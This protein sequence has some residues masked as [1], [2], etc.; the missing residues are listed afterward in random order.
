[1]THHAFVFDEGTYKSTIYGPLFESELV[2]NEA[3]KALATLYDPDYDIGLGSEWSATRTALAELFPEGIAFLTGAEVPGFSGWY[4]QSAA[5]V[6]RNAML[7]EEAAD[8]DALNRERILKA[9]EM[10][11]KAEGCG[12]L[13]RIG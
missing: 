10:F 1:M 11:G 3:E 5:V 4:T 2:H 9:A 13:V 12:L 6:R 7:L 8:R